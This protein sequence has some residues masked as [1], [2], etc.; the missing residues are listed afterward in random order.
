MTKPIEALS[1]DDVAAFRA[2]IAP[3]VLAILGAAGHAI[4][5]GGAQPT[6]DGPYLWIDTSGGTPT[7]WLEDGQ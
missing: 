1:G 5:I 2:A 4:F 6:F 3:H 7:F